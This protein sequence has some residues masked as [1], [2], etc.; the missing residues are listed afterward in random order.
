MNSNG[1]RRHG[2][3]CDV[4][5]PEVWYNSKTFQ[6]LEVVPKRMDDGTYR[7]EVQLKDLTSRGP[8]IT[9]IGRSYN[10][11]S[12]NGMQKSFTRRSSA[13]NLAVDFMLRRNLE[14]IAEY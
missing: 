2:Y 13:H 5:G 3:D 14:T 11:I 4:R 7:F 8:R 1:W 6:R 9:R 12:G 10:E